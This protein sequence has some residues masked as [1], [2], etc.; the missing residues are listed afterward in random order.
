FAALYFRPFI[1]LVGIWL[2]DDNVS[3]SMLIPPIVAYVVWTKREALRTTEL[4]PAPAG[5]LIVVVSLGV[6][7]LGT[8]GVEFFLMRS[9]GLGVLI[10]SVAYIA[11]WRWLRILAFPIALCALMIPIPPVIFY[12]ITFPLQIWATRFGVSLLQ[13]LQIPV[14]REGNVILL[15]QT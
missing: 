2:A 9:S 5:L 12:Q 1:D 7:L 11:G 6:L 15:P 4:V 14:L 13:L 10:G 8:A 3:Y